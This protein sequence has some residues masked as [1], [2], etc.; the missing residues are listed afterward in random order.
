MMNAMNA[1]TM[2]E[3]TLPISNGGSLLVRDFQPTKPGRSGVMI[4]H[5]L[6][7]HS[8][9]YLHV[10]EFFCKLG[11]AVRIYDQRGHGLS[12][13]SRGDIPEPDTFIHD[14]ALVMED[15]INTGLSL[16]EKP[17]LLGHS[18]GGLFAAHFAVTKRMPISGLILSSPALA[19]PLTGSQKVLLKTLSAIAPGLRV[20]NGLK[21]HYLSHDRKVE[22][23]YSEDKLVHN[24]ITSRLLNNMLSS[25]EVVQRD[26]DQIDI[27][28]L[29]VFAGQDHLVDARGSDE[30]FSHLTDKIGTKHRYAQLYHEIF[31]ELPA[32]A[33]AVFAD[34]KHWLMHS[35]T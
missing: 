17:L 22:E 12:S 2:I 5:G 14:A 16:T 19:L 24:K 27:P 21:R 3:S 13:G 11:Y 32:D 30:F 18:M 20:P 26:A 15:W 10:A 25:I 4:M 8:G 34:V 28:V 35:L 23:A 6:G 9:R 7:E 29:L 33:D 31:N 1:S